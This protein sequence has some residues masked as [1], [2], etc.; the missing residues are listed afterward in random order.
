MRNKSQK[1]NPIEL[2]VIRGETLGVAVY[3]GYARLCDLAAMSKPD[4]YDAKS[5]LTG[6]QRDLS[7]R[8]AREAYEY[9]R[10][11]DIGFWPEVF[12]CVR[13]KKIIEFM[14]S[15]Q[16]DDFGTIF[17]DIKKILSSKKISISRVDG[18]H[19]LHYADGSEPDFPAIEKIASFCIAYNLKFEQEIV[20]FRDI[21]ANQKAMN[22][23]HLDNIESRLSQEDVLKREHPDLYIA[24]MLG[25]DDQSPLYERVF[26]GGKKPIGAEIPLRA[27]RSGISYLLSRPT[28]LSALRD[29][30]AQ[31]R[32]IK[33][34]FHALKKWAPDSWVEPKKYLMLRGAGLWGVCF[35]GAEV[36]DRSLGRAKFASDDMLEILKSGK[37]WDWSNKGDFQGYSGRGGASKISDT[38]TAEFSDE[39]GVSVKTLYNKIMSEK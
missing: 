12:L 10:S 37:Q 31:Y 2:N 4:I 25:R 27:L 6:T 5:N 39:K 22:T 28:K 34:Y 38:V 21:N 9:A 29:P 8:H 26:E 36:I 11:H 19:R 30:D 14:P 17:I 16:S 35:I 7:P 20:L 23:S 1:Y 18:N 33:N 32:V 13:D 24:R 3:R 15:K